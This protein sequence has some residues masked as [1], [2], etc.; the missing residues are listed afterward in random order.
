MNNHSITFINQTN[1]SINIETFEKVLPGLCEMKTICVNSN[2]TISMI[3]E[4]GEWILENYLFD[5]KMCNEWEKIGVP[6]G[7]TI[8]IIR[9]KSCY[10][11][12]FCWLYRD[13]LELIFEL[14]YNSS[15]KTATLT[16]K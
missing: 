3:S 12:E 2:E 7:E 4:T 5:T 10:T 11:G 14:N 9:D 8:G 6:P 13:K 1:L 15:T 16:Q